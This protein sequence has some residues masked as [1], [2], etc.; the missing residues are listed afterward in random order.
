VEKRQG[1]NE[2]VTVNQYWEIFYAIVANIPFTVGLILGFKQF[3]KQ[4]G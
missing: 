1:V 2:W 4:R 3:K